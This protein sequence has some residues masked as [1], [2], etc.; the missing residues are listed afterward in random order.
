MRLVFGFKFAC[1]YCGTSGKRI[2]PLMQAG[3]QFCVCLRDELVEGEKL[4]DFAIILCLAC[5]STTVNVQVRIVQKD[6][7]H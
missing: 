3:W 5:S 4:V 6:P 7:D 1:I 2:Y